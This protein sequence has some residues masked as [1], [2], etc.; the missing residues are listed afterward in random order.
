MAYRK[1]QIPMTLSDVQGH[2]LMPFQMWFF[3]H[4]YSNWQARY[5]C[6]KWVFSCY[7]HFCIR[8]LRTLI[9]DLFDLKT[10]SLLYVTWPVFASGLF[11]L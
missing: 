8:D 9:F 3:V 6:D 5:L 7:K 1:V 2:S 4:M 10:C 11:F